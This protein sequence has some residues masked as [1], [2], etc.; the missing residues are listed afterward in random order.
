VS[1]ELLDIELGIVEEAADLL[2]QRQPAG[3]YHAAKIFYYLTVWGDAWM[4][5]GPEHTAVKLAR[6]PPQATAVDLPPQEIIAAVVC[7]KEVG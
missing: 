1:D 7:L 2:D 4:F 5:Y 6:L 3:I